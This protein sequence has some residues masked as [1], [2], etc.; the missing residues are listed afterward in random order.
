MRSR[1]LGQT[2]LMVS[3]IGMGCA[4]YWGLPAFD[5]KKALGLVHAAIEGGVTFFD[6]GASYSHGHAEPRLGR[7]LRSHSGRDLVIATKAGT[8]HA[9]GGRIVRDFSVPALEASILRSLDNL[10]LD[11]LPLLQLHGPAAHELD[12][13]LLEGLEG[14]RRRGLFRALGI[15]SFDPAVIE[16]ALALPN[17]DVV[18]IDY[19][20]MRP[21]RAP[22]IAAA[23]AAGKGVLAGMALA[24]GRPSLRPTRMRGMQD[25]WYALRALKNH[26]ADLARA[27]RYGFLDRIPHMT[28]AQASLAYVLADPRVSCA[29]MGTTRVE[30]LRDNLAASGLTLPDD[31]LAEIRRAQAE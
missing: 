9:G 7:A 25:V 5:E 11:H 27:S 24:M 10:G 21:E 30:H 16:V 26:R 13:R 14:L 8:Q 2:G 23:T 1:P 4:S 3:E 20:V 15:N 12:A 31:L 28:G 6:T 18:M 29:V 19:N 17:F 22:L